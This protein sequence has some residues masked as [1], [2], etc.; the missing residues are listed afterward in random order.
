MVDSDTDM[1]VLRIEL[2]NEM[3]WSKMVL[4]IDQESDKP[5]IAEPFHVYY[6]E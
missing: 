1:N 6:I 2:L 4:Y 3:C 5:D